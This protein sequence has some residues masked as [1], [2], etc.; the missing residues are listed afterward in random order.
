MQTGFILSTHLGFQFLLFTL[1][2][3]TR[4]RRRRIR[5]NSQIHSLYYLDALFPL[6]L[7]F[8]HSPSR[9]QFCLPLFLFC[10][11]FAVFL[12]CRFR[13]FLFQ[14]HFSWFFSIFFGSRLPFIL[15]S[16]AFVIPF[17][18][19]KQ[20]EIFACCLLCIYVILERYT[21]Y[22]CFMAIL[23]IIFFCIAYSEC[24]ASVRR[25]TSAFLSRI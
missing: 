5:K 24:S 1:A 11:L 18:P 22:F 25:N 13:L 8:S 7:S 17:P 16:A 21:L 4:R 14:Y 23:F 3:A 10:F 20:E 12:T 19:Q 6:F 15:A 2:Y 9:T